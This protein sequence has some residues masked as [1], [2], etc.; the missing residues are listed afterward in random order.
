MR[1]VSRDL[2]P[3]ARDFPAASKRLCDA[4]AACLMAM[5]TQQHVCQKQQSHRH[6]QE[7]LGISCTLCDVQG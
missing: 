6:F 1:V 2:Q 4:D 7:D 3:P 5:S